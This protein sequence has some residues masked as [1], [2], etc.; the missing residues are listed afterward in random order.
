MKSGEGKKRVHNQEDGGSEKGGEV[1]HLLHC[2]EECQRSLRMVSLLE[3][4]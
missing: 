2:Q 1:T 3:S 4:F